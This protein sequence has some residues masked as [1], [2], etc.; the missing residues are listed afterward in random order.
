MGTELPNLDP[1]PTTIVPDLTVSGLPSATIDIPTGSINSDG[2]RAQ[3]PLHSD[4]PSQT[5]PCNTTITSTTQPLTGTT[6]PVVQ[7]VV[8]GSTYHRIPDMSHSRPVLPPNVY[9]SDHYPHYPVHSSPTINPVFQSQIHSGPYRS[10]VFHN[11]N[12]QIR[13]NEDNP[14]FLGSGDHPGLVLVTPPL[15]DHN[16]QQ[17]RRDFRLALGAKNKTGFIDGTIQQPAPTNPLYH[18]WIRCNQMVMSWIIHSVSLDIKSS[19]LFLDS[20]ADMWTELTN[21]FSQGNGPRLF[22][23]NDSLTRLRQGDDSV[24]A[25]FTK[26]RAI[27]DEINELRPCLPCTCQASAD[28]IRYQNQEKVMCFLTGLNESYHAIRAQVLILDPFP[29]LAKVFSTIIQHERQRNIGLQPNL[30]AA[31]SPNVPAAVPNKNKRQR[32]FCT[33]CEKPGHL[34][35]KCFILHGFPPGFVD[36]RSQNRPSDR[37]TT[38]KAPTA[39]SATASPAPISPSVND[40]LSTLHDMITQLQS[41]I[42]QGRA[43][44]AVTTPIASNLTG[45][46]SWII[47][48]GATHHVCF[49]LACFSSFHDHPIASYITLPNGSKISVAKSGTVH[50]NPHLLL[51]NV[52]FVPEFHYNLL[53]VSA[54]LAKSQYHILF[55]K[56]ECFFQDITR[57]IRIGT[58]E[59]IGQLFIIHQVPHNCNSVSKDGCI[60]STFT[61]F[62]KWHLRLGHPSIT[63]Y[64][65]QN[66][67]F[68]FLVIFVI[69]LETFIFSYY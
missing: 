32:P 39:N 28:I 31:A 27:W 34:K 9:R 2:S 21:R 13:T 44:T 11:S 35:E 55:T 63:F 33:H 41:Q 10:D 15:S 23:L 43:P 45:K 49:D 30:T 47:D 14:Y 16:F 58:A 54:I 38:P 59:R 12:S 1:Y 48:S 24:T 42:H 29:S 68:L 18:S 36:K 52:L 51:H 61:D 7:P 4:L 56:N 46:V 3:I 40:K 66:M 69:S 22:D 17:W 62:H 67:I 37:K 64:N 25:Y 26:L 50:L 60:F 57:N 8:S 53:S 5:E 6:V 20:A 19:I 65:F